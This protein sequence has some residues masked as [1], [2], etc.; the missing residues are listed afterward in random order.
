MNSWLSILEPPEY[1]V[2]GKAQLPPEPQIDA[3]DDLSDSEADV[4]RCF[5]AHPDTALTVPYIRQWLDDKWTSRV[6]S[7]ALRQLMLAGVVTRFNH[8]DAGAKFIY[9]AV[10]KSK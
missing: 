7:N 3:Y 6:I 5:A 4:M 10:R 1:I 2:R 8:M 9:V